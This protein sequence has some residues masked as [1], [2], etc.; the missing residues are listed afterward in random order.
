M[1]TFSYCTNSH[2]FYQYKVSANDLS[3]AIDIIRLKFN[4]KKLEKNNCL[5]IEIWHGEKD[6]RL[7]TF[8]DLNNIT[9]IYK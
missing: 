1:D 5:P 4:F 8:D 2:A 7:F 6:R 9:K 3:D